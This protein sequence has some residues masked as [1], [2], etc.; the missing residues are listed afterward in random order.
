MRLKL[1]ERGK[2]RK[3]KDKRL[4]SNSLSRNRSKRFIKKRS[5]LMNQ[6]YIE[7][8][9][10][11]FPLKE[12]KVGGKELKLDPSKKIRERIIVQMKKRKQN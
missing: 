1:K 10:K 5:K 4:K 2:G 11:R 3:K 8:L 6:R 9:L 12:Q 7:S